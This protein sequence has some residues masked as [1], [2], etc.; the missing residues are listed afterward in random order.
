M[1]CNETH[2]VVEEEEATEE[3]EEVGGEQ[4]QVDGSSAG[5]LHHHGHEAVQ[6]VH[7]QGVD[8]KQEGCTARGQELDS[9]N[10]QL[11][12]TLI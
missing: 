8:C 2:F 12:N 9:G 10:H 7:A 4:G 1:L 3:A 11:S 6:G 5:H